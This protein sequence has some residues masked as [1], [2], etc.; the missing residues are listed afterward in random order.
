[1]HTQHHVLFWFNQDCH[2]KVAFSKWS[3]CSQ[4]LT[5]NVWGFMVLSR[6]SIPNTLKFGICNFQRICKLYSEK[7]DINIYMK[8][9][10]FGTGYILF[11][12]IRARKP[13]HIRTENAN[14]HWNL[15][16]AEAAVICQDLPWMAT[17]RFPMEFRVGAKC[18]CEPSGEHVRNGHQFQSAA[19]CMGCQQCGGHV[20]NV[21][22]GRELQWGHLWMERCQR[23]EN[24]VP[25]LASALASNHLGK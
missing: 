3:N 24:G 22:R 7:Q 5:F 6:L 17:S 21:Q 23:W 4:K 25:A 1:M 8:V 9:M 10:F 14:G 18:R 20:P 15:K 11:N 16:N 2:S 13:I 19:H 12:E